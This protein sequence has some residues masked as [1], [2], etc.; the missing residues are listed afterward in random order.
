MDRPVRFF[1]R[2]FMKFFEEYYTNW[3]VAEPVEDFSGSEKTAF[4]MGIKAAIA[5]LRYADQ[6]YPG[7]AV[8]KNRRMCAAFLEQELKTILEER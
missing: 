5:R 6:P 8:V 3:L 7:A 4:N 2:R 1:K